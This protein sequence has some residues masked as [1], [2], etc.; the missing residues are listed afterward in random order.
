MDLR[1]RLLMGLVISA[2][3]ISC[4]SACLGIGPAGEEGKGQ[5]PRWEQSYDA[6]YTDGKG[7]YAGGSEIMHLVAHKGKLYAANVGE[8]SV[9]GSDSSENAKIEI[10]F[11]F[12]K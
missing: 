11:F 3:I 2:G 7:A 9:H 1:R 12:N 10:N 6:G 8:N 4:L 5:E